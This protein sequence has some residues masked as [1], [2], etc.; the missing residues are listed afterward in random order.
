M[1]HSS[2]L[3]ELSFANEFLSRHIGPDDE[4]AQQMLKQLDLDSLEA[5]IDKTVPNSIRSETT[6]KLKAAI[7]EHQ[8]LA[9]LKSIAS[10]NQVFKSYLG[11]GYHDTHVPNVILRNVLENP[12]W[13]T[14]YTPYQ[15]E[16]AQ[17]RLEGLLNFQ[18]MVTEL[19]GMD[20]AN[21]SML[22]ESTAAAEAMAMA[23]RVARKNK[24]NTFFVDQYCHP[25]TLAVIQTRAD[26]RQHSPNKR[27]FCRC[28]D[29]FKKFHLILRGNKS[30]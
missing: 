16:I 20:L 8:A 11:Q 4:Q 23:K 26:A 30:R 21:A 24:S 3:N 1:N 19:T 5:L 14:A 27:A 18:Q 25:Q 7:G 9:E 12:G 28:D 29:K 2:S 17:G 6:Q 10:K 22:D 13:Y 15:P